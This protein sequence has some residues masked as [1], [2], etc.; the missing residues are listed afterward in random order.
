[1][2]L[3]APLSAGFTDHSQ[4]SRTVETSSRREVSTVRAKMG[5]F[6]PLA[7]SSG[8]V[9]GSAPCAASCH[10]GIL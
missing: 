6:R 7:C 4:R 9:A 10:E 8:Y 2:G 3:F 5:L 1:M